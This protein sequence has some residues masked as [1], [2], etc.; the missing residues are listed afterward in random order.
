MGMGA[1]LGWHRRAAVILV[2]QLPD[3][4]NDALLVLQAA[5]DLVEDFLVGHADEPENVASNVI[6]FGGSSG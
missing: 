6:P 1:P 4:T 2:G 5:K 3:G